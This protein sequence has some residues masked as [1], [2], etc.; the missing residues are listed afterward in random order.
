MSIYADQFDVLVATTLDAVRP[1]LRDQISNENALLAWLNS[2]AR[3]TLDGG[4]V[5]RRPLLYAFN[6]TVSSYSGYDLIDTTP[7]EG[8]GWAEYEWRQHAGSFVISGE[9][10]RKNSGS[11]QLISLV[12]SKIDQLKLSVADDLNAMLWSDGQGNGGKDMLGIKALVGD[13]TANGT[14]GTD[15]HV[16]GID[17][18]TYTWWRSVVKS[19]PVDLTDPAGVASLN[20]VYNT[21]RVNR[22]KVDVE[23]TTQANFEAYEAMAVPNIRFTNLRAADLG[24]ETIAHKTAEVIFE[25]DVPSSGD[26]SDGAHTFAGGGGWFFLNSDRLEFV[27]HEDAWLTMTDMQRPY[28]QDA[29]VALILSMGNLITDSRRSHG[30][31]FE[32]VV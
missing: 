24:F 12:Q 30:V 10:I 26:S 8:L 3:V 9:E 23:F 28:N 11:R 1:V 7:Q 5:I 20:N 2:K 21:I 31:I 19:T 6:D 15:V 32:T 29:K 17:A 27:Q 14:A 22:S 16:G 4:S 25:P 18:A 13:D